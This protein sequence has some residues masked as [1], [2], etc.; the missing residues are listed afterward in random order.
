MRLLAA[1]NRRASSHR[2]RERLTRCRW[3][4]NGSAARVGWAIERAPEPGTDRG[5]RWVVDDLARAR[6]P[7]AADEGRRAS[8]SNLDARPRVPAGRAATVPAGI[9]ERSTARCRRSGA[10][11]APRDALVGGSGARRVDARRRGRSVLRKARVGGQR[12]GAVLGSAGVDRGDGR[13][14]RGERVGHP[15]RGVRGQRLAS[16]KVVRSCDDRRQR[17]RAA[18]NREERE[19]SGQ[20]HFAGCGRR[21]RGVNGEGKSP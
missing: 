1:V 15:V 11:L 14:F 8:G 17:T 10:R 19:P 9:G 3:G 7:F 12:Q 4:H 2:A 20:G 5:A 16:I 13:V 18:N 6:L 21:A